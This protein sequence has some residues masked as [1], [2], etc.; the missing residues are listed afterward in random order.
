MEEYCLGTGGSQ[1]TRVTQYGKP[2]MEDS[3]IHRFK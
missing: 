3:E 2:D 1:V